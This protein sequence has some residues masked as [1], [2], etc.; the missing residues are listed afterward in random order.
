M[1]IIA[2]SR[3][4]VTLWVCLLLTVLLPV[5]RASRADGQV[6]IYQAVADVSKGGDFYIVNNTNATISFTVTNMTFRNPFNTTTIEPWGAAATTDIDLTKMSGNGNNAGLTFQFSARANVPACTLQIQAGADNLG[7][8][9]SL[10]GDSSFSTPKDPWTPSPSG[11]YPYP[12]VEVGADNVYQIFNSSYVAT[13]MAGAGTDNGTA[14]HT[15][16]TTGTKVVLVI[17]QNSSRTLYQQ[18]GNFGYSKN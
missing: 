10:Y 13:L 6:T 7:V 11:A 18:G 2:T 3:E 16:P 14:T 5:L 15:H 12:A 8:A 4:R 17:S 1:A 9:W